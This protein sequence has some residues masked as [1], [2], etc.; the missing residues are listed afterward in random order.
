M[1]GHVA[2]LESLSGT[3]SVSDQPPSPGVEV[4]VVNIVEAK[5]IVDIM[6]TG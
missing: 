1:P 4:I 2:E 5:N 6:A 3:G